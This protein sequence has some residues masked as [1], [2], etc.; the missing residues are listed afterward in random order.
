MFEGHKSPNLLLRYAT[1]KLVMQEVAYHLSTWLLGILHIKK[2]APWHVPLL[3]IGLYEIKNLKAGDTEGKE[4][5]KFTFVHLDYN[6]Y[7]KNVSKENYP[8]IHFQ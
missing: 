1:T 5:E 4:I 8:R 7:P 2:K 3:Q 6:H